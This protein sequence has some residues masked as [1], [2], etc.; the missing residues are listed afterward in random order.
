MATTCLSDV[1]GKLPGTECAIDQD[2]PV[3]I[4]HVDTLIFG[5][6]LKHVA[7]MLDRAAASALDRGTTLD[8]DLVLFVEQ[9][10]CDRLERQSVIEQ[11]VMAQ[12]TG[13]DRDMLPFRMVELRVQ[14]FAS[15]FARGQMLHQHP[16]RAHARFV[17]AYRAADQRGH[18]FGLVEIALAG[19]G[20]AVPFERDDTLIPPLVAGKVES[21]REIALAEQREERGVRAQ[22]GKLGR[23]E[24]DIAGG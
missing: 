1:D 20:E 11:F 17:R 4:A 5:E 12:R 14:A 3:L 7:I 15:F 8:A 13:K 2:D 22:F 6:P 24:I 18:L 19:F 23:V 16:C 9:A 21:D 10:P